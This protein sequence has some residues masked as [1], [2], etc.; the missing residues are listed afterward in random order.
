MRRWKQ[1]AIASGFVWDPVF[2]PV[3]EGTA[4][5]RE[6]HLKPKRSRFCSGSAGVATQGRRKW[7]CRSGPNEIH[8]FVLES[9]GSALNLSCPTP[10]MKNTVSGYFI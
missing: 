2:L 7:P 5:D 6:V 10:E 9:A 8:G 1:I 4:I 3:G